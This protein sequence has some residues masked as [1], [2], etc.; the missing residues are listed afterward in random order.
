MKK[1]KIFLILF[2]LTL[3]FNSSAQENRV[4]DIIFLID[5]SGSIGK[6]ELDTLSFFIDNLKE[7]TYIG[8]ISF[9]EEAKILF[10]LQPAKE[11]KIKS[12]L[13]EFNFKENYT[14]LNSGLNLSLNEFYKNSRKNSSKILILISDG[15][16][17]IKDKKIT[18]KNL[19][20]EVIEEIIPNF[21][22]Q[23][24][25]IYTIVC[26]KKQANF[27]LLKQI[28]KETRGEMF[29][30]V[31]KDDLK[32]ALEKILEFITPKI[33]EKVVP[34]KRIEGKF[35]ILIGLL[36]VFFIFLF[37]LIRKRPSP[38]TPEDLFE[39]IFEN[40]EEIK[41]TL[42]KSET[43]IDTLWSDIGDYGTKKIREINKLREE[44]YGF[45]NFIFYFMDFLEDLSK[46]EKNKEIVTF[47]YEKMKQILRRAGIEEIQ[48]NEK[49]DKYNPDLHYPTK[50][51]HLSEFE[52][53]VILN[54]IKKGYIKNNSVLRKAEVTINKKPK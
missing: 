53:E 13:K 14:N 37:Q 49:S 33:S 35:W 29:P 51:E 36:S 4:Y 9:G 30:Y 44:H 21:K 45:L 8:I 47:I 12:V 2:L 54:V 5:N 31:E 39:G 16:I 48:I 41:K 18:K 3:F 23:N 50:V 11:E 24:I 19:E 22:T 7:E 15:I 17:D 32:T 10:S 1:F 20:K 27:P 52:D 6:L 42:K 34:E 25:S 28:S 26:C 43:F 40:L 46:N 38:K